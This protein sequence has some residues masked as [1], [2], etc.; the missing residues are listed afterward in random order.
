MIVLSFSS[1]GGEKVTGIPRFVEITSSS[2]ATIYYTLDGTLPTQ[3]SSVYTDPVEMPTDSGSV[4]LSAVGYYLDGNNNLVPTPVLSNIYKVDMSDIGDR[5]IYFNAIAYMYPGGLDIPYWYDSSG[6]ASVFIDVPAEDLDLLV[7][8]RDHQGYYREVGN[9]AW[10]PISQ[11][12][13]IPPGETASL[14]DDNYNLYDTPSSATFN[15][16]SYYIVIDGRNGDSLDD[17]L[18]I[19]G[20]HMDLRDPRRHF[21]GLDFL[22]TNNTNYRS[23]H[24]TKYHYDRSRGIIVFYYFDTN[25]CRWIKSIQNLEEV[26]IASLPKPY[27]GNPV[28]FK[29]NNW[30]RQQ[31]V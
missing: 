29:W 15:P 11:I 17:T 27:I 12:D 24:L 3:L 31:S 7:S 16:E 21:G 13:R 2:P 26:D 20:P 14:Y 19:N 23:G 5:Y 6:E 30:G 1:L 9:E 28:V 22:V 8:D 4:T 25:S 18:L 10:Y